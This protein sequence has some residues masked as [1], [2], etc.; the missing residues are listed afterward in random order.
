MVGDCI[1]IWKYKNIFGKDD[2]L[3]WSEEVF[4]VN[5]VIMCLGHVLLVILMVKK[6]LKLITKKNSKRQ[7]KK[8]LG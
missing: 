8:N 2:V 1:R 7:I 5:K 4:M 3:N 6:F